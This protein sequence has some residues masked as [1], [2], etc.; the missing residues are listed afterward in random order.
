M[1]LDINEIVQIFT[2]KLG[3]KEK[4]NVLLHAEII[5]LNKHIEGLKEEIQDLEKQLEPLPELVQ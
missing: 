1:Q 2:N 4:E 5:Q 3:E